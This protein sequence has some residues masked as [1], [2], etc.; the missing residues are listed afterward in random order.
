MFDPLKSNV[1]ASCIAWFCDIA[2]HIRPIVLFT[3]N[4]ILAKLKGMGHAVSQCACKGQALWSQCQ[5]K[6]ITVGKQILIQVFME[7]N[8]IKYGDAQIYS[9]LFTN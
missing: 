6:N 1:K 7:F 5:G 8:L 9:K 2:N 3:Q 4:I